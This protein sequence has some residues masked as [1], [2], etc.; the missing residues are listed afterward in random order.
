[1]DY[2]LI[3]QTIKNEIQS[4]AST[5]TVATYIPELAKVPPNK[6]GMHINCM[7]NGTHSFGDSD[8]RFSIQSISKV[9]SLTLAMTLMGDEL[10]DRVDVEP[11]G[12][13]FNSLFQLEHEEGIPRNPFINAGALV[14]SDILISK[15]KHPK[16]EFLAFVR[17]LAK[18]KSITIDQ[19]VFDSE[20]E[21]I[22]RNAALI[23]LMKS[24]GNIEND[25]EEV[26]DLYVYQCAIAMSCAEL[27]KAFEIYAN[28]GSFFNSEEQ[29]ITSRKTKRINAIM[30][31]CGFY[32][33]AGEFSFRVGLPGK[34]GVGGGI[35]A[36]H[37]GQYTVAVWSPPLNP[38]GNSELGM[39]ALERLTTL[40]GLSIF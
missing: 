39:Y 9:F 33:E 25:I 30:Q 4:L 26:L 36:V 29:L 32:D 34:S 38:R 14:I 24:F 31:T 7:S 21:H 15:L 2:H 5:G 6:F 27:S 22:Y 13:P 11:S 8:E 12:D 1:M 16:K 20:L 3:L 40:T 19:N 28:S 10:F 35:V 18:D 37:P 23:N 17:K